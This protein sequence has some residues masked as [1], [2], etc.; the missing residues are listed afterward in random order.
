M[1]NRTIIENPALELSLE[2][3][4]AYPNWIYDQPA[5]D[6]SFNIAYHPIKETHVLMHMWFLVVSSDKGWFL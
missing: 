2:T 6:G 5:L 1:E 3:L 4:R